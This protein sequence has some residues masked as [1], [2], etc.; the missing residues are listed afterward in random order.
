MSYQQNIKVS[1]AL[2]KGQRWI[3]IPAV[4]I[5]CFFM[6]VCLPILLYAFREDKNN[7]AVSILG[8][9]FIL[10]G[11]ILP[12]VWYGINVVKF[13]IWVGKNVKDIHRFQEEALNKKLINESKFFKRIE[14]KSQSQKIELKKFYYNRL[15]E[16]RKLVIDINKEVERDTF[17][18]PSLTNSIIFIM[19]IV[20]MF[21]FKEFYEDNRR[22]LYGFGG[23]GLGFVIWD[24][25][26]YFR[27]TYILK[28]N[29]EY[30]SYKNNKEIVYWKNIQNF[31]IIL[32]YY[33]RPT[34][35][36]INT[37]DKNYSWTLDNFFKQ[38]TNK[39][40]NVLNENKHRF[41]LKSL[42]A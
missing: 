23:I 41:D 12:F 13:K 39:V 9:S 32:G 26:K 25:F 42:K 18:K 31:N 2:K 3:N 37:I 38:K 16:D 22:L 36:N 4:L 11:I 35:L 27:Y 14:I 30:I 33:N 29:D 6:F 1:E 28:I 24:L 19:L 7:V 8:V 15:K 34:E 10:L 5:L 17:F 21:F 40:L 20:G